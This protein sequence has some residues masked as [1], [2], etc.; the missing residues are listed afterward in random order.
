MCWGV[1]S[2]P[3]PVPVPPPRARGGRRRGSWR[4]GWVVAWGE[5]AAGGWGGGRCS[6]SAAMRGAGSPRVERAGLAVVPTRVRT[7]GRVCQIA[8]GPCHRKCS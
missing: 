3:P 1:S 2:A 5:G 6:W 8:L 4:T 7:L